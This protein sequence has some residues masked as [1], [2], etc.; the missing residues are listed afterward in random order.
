MSRA[1][2]RMRRSSSGSRS[3]AATSMCRSVVLGERQAR[4][5]RPL[6]RAKA[7]RGT[8]R[9]RAG[10]ALSPRDADR[11]ADPRCAAAPSAEDEP[12]CSDERLREKEFGILDGLTVAG[13][14]RC[15]PRPGRVPPRARQ[16]LSPPARRRELVRRDPAPAHAARHRLAPLCR[17]ARDDRRASGRRAVPAL[18]HREARRDGR[19]WRSTAKATSPTAPSPNIASIAKAGKDGGLVLARYN[20][21]APVEDEAVPVTARHGPDRS[22]RADERRPSDRR[23]LARGPSAAGSGRR[24]GQER[25]RPGAAGRRLGVGARRGR[26]DRRGDPARRCRQGADRDDRPRGDRDRSCS[27]PKRR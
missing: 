11:A 22:R 9:C 13:I 24:A 8:A 26:A 5:A 2:P 27:F 7:G 12:L 19:S 14:A 10:L 21:T 15:I 3:P 25:A 4:R 16:I 1:M 18:H 23:R 20:R 17:A 6:V